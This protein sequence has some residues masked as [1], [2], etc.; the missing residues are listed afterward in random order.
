MVPIILAIAILLCMVWYLF[1]YDREFTR[2]MLLGCAR[3]SESNGYHEVATWFYN[4]AYSHSG[5]NDAVAIELAEQYVSDGNYT[6]AEYT[7]TNAIANGAGIDVYIALCDTYVQQDKLLDAVNMLNNVTNPEIKAQLDEMRPAAPVATPEPG[8]YRQYISVTLTLSEGTTYVS[9]NGEYP[10][11]K[12]SVYT[13]GITL[14]DGENTIYAITVSENGLVSPVSIYGYTVGGV[15]ELMEFADPAIETEV[16]TLLNVTEETVLYTN[17]LWQIT[18]FEMPEGAKIY[19][20]LKHMAFLEVLTIENGVSDELTNLSSLANLTTLKITNTAVSESVLTSIAALPVLKNLTLTDCDLTTISPLKS[21][22]GIVTLDLSKNLISN[23]EPISVMTGLTELNLYSNAVKDISP[24]RSNTALTKL[25]VST[26]A[27]TSLAPIENL[28][29]LTS[30][31]ASTNSIST[32]GS[33]EK[34]TS[35]TYLSLNT[36]KLTD[37]SDLASC[38]SITELY[39]STNALK[40]ISSLSSLTSLLY[41]DFSYNEVTTIPSF[42]KDCALVIINGTKNKLSSLSPLADLEN[43]NRVYMDYN[44]DISSVSELADCPVLIEVNVY[45]T[46]VTDVTSLTNQSIIVNYSPIQDEE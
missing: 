25:N 33:F 22:T 35:L 2:D 45:A 1:I 11:V 3:M 31:D 16:R 26:N 19:S 46:K 44:S 8:F 37:V 27:I 39:I 13:D 29:S 34:L 14:S 10:T 7:L 17:D 24:L 15:I 20:D 38:T 9:T 30:V 6:K 18:E 32:L 21:A 43:L 41:F 42:P 23:I 5:D 28:T 4:A 36:N 40:D 12:G